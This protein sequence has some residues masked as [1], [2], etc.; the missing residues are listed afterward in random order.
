[1]GLHKWGQPIP[2][3]DGLFLPILPLQSV[4]FR[5]RHLTP[6]GGTMKLTF[7]TLRIA[8]ALGL[9]AGMMIGCQDLLNP[10]NTASDPSATATDQTGSLSLSIKND[11]SCQSEWHSILA[12]RSA[13]HP[14]SASEAAFLATCVTEV[15]PVKD[16][17]MPVVP[18]PLLPESGTRCKW[19]V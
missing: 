7:P 12:A 11:S 19:I 5:T 6:Y 9:A 15:K 4:S 14:D 13:G 2:A 16:K 17:P 1:M 10:G 8:A 3:F 18:P